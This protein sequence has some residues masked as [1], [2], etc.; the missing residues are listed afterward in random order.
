[1]KKILFSYILLIFYSLLLFPQGITIP[2]PGIV[3]YH[4][5][6]KLYNYRVLNSESYT[7][8]NV[9]GPG[10]LTATFRARLKNNGNEPSFYDIIYV[11]DSTKIRSFQVKDVLPLSNGAYIQ[12]STDKPSE[13]GVLVLKIKPDVQLIGF[14]MKNKT[15]QVDFR[16][17]FVSDTLKNYYWKNLKSGNDRTPIQLKSVS[18]PVTQS[19]YRISFNKNQKIKVKGPTIIRVFSRLEYDYAM[20]GI[21]SY[22]IQAKRDDGYTKTFKLSCN[23]SREAQYVNN[24]KFVPGTL[25]KFYIE[26]PKGTHTYE[27]TLLDKH[28]SALMRVSKQ[29]K[30][31]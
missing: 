19:Y 24:K 16:Y 31:K 27:F 10:E 11:V 9:N 28:F 6:G 30:K 8:I 14:R 3:K 25:E 26:V 1:M 5:D 29:E 23:P 4:I 2:K 17:K 15:P 20:Q 22:R 13:T 18:K 21:L 7:Y 12:S